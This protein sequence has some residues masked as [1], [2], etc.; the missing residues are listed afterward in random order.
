M[1]FLEVLH[2]VLRQGVENILCEQLRDSGRGNFFEFTHR[3]HRVIMMPSDIWFNQHTTVFC[4]QISFSR[5][6]LSLYTTYLVPKGMWVHHPGNITTTSQISA[7]LNVIYLLSVSHYRLC[8]LWLHPQALVQI[9]SISMK[10]MV[11][12]ILFKNLSCHIWSWEM[13]KYERKTCESN[14]PFLFFSL[15]P[16]PFS[17]PIHSSSPPPIAPLARA[18]STSSISSTNSLSAPPLPQLVKIISLSF[19][20]FV[21]LTGYFLWSETLTPYVSGQNCFAVCFATIIWLFF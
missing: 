19:N 11:P 9:Q 5:Y 16:R 12:P 14:F 18:E 10:K 20:P 2:H 4:V 13:L 1:N 8:F 3:S 21:V 15:Q 17:P 7:S 6:K